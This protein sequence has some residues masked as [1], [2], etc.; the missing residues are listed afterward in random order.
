VDLLTNYYQFR[1]AILGL[2]KFGQI[3][4]KQ[5]KTLIFQSVNKPL[6]PR[7]F[8][9]T[10]KITEYE[11]DKRAMLPSNFLTTKM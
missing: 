10:P 3:E 8:N 9:L 4:P 11:R 1:P 2:D 7:L 5:V 6:V